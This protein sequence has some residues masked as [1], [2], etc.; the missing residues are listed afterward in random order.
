MKGRQPPDR[1]RIYRD[2]ETG[3]EIEYRPV[4]SARPYRALRYLPFPVQ[5][6][7]LRWLAFF[8]L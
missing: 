8:G 5:R 7:A 2:D 6:A 1:I 4:P 3:A